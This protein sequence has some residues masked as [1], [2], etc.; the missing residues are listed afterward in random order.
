M[1]LPTLADFAAVWWLIALVAGFPLFLMLCAWLVC[2]A[3]TRDDDNPAP[4][5]W[6]RT[7]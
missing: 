6:R 4:G 3:P 5:R 2:R 1:T 7:R